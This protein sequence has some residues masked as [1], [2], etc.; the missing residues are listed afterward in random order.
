MMHNQPYALDKTV[1]KERKFEDVL[2]DTYTRL[3]GLE[4]RLREH[5]VEAIKR[6]AEDPAEGIAW[7]AE[8]AVASQTQLSVLTEIKFLINKSETVEDVRANFTTFTS[9]YRAQIIGWASYG[10]NSSSG[11]SNTTSRVNLS[12]TADLFGTWGLAN[13]IE[14]S[15]ES[16]IQETH[17]RVVVKE[18]VDLKVDET[19]RLSPDTSNMLLRKLSPR[20]A[21]ECTY[22]SNKATKHTVETRTKVY[23]FRVP[24]ESDVLYED[25]GAVAA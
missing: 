18:F 8:S 21:I 17:K 3:D 19:F 16:D 24:L 5:I 10:E 20:K 13:D 23:L 6:I 1:V 11:F 9:R 2:K 14:H 25:N 22:P 12:A 15:I 4:T 7:R